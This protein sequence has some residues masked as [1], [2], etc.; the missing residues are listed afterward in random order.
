V[1]SKVAGITE[2]QAGGATLCDVAYKKWGAET[3]PSLFVRSTI[4]SRP[5]PDR[6]VCDAGLKTMLPWVYPP[7]P[8]GLTGVQDIKVTAEHIRLQLEKP[9]SSLKVGDFLDFIPNYGDITVFLH[10][11]LYGV[12]DGRVEV[13]W[14]IAARGKLR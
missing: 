11:Y 7:Q 4:T 10:D 12:R 3:E 14:P 13:I 2:I 6:I 8:L 1:A 5:V 9:D